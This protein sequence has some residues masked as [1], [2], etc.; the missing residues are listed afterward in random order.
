[1]TGWYTSRQISVDPSTNGAYLGRLV[2]FVEWNNPDLLSS[3]VVLINVEDVYILFNRRIGPNVESQ[4][5]YDLV[6][7]TQGTSSRS[8]NLAGLNSTQ[9]F[10]YTGYNGTASTL[11][12]EVCD[13]AFGTSFDYALVSLY[14]Q[15]SQS[16]LCSSTTPAPIALQ[17][18]TPSIAPTPKA[19]TAQPVVT[20]QTA[21]PSFE[22]TT[23]SPDTFNP[24]STFPATLPPSS[25]SGPAST[26]PATLPPSS[27]SGS[28]LLTPPSA[29]LSTYQPSP[30]AATFSPTRA[31]SIAPTRVATNPPTPQVA[32]SP[33]TQQ[34]TNMLPTPLL[35][36][37]P[38]PVATT[39]NPTSIAT[40]NKPTILA[41]TGQPSALATTGQPSALAT[42]H[43]PVGSPSN[44]PLA[45]PS[46][47]PKTP[48]LSTATTHPVT[49]RPTVNSTPIFNSS[50]TRD[51]GPAPASGPQV[52]PPYLFMV[53]PQN[54]T[55]QNMWLAHFV[56][57][58]VLHFFHTH[59]LIW[60]SLVRACVCMYSFFF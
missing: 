15:G 17:T 31:A 52:V 49:R 50:D 56:F 12:I 36:N 11:M 47:A 5:D 28:T 24:A 55:K 39:N 23:L 32:T 25:G 27:G 57:H 1:M 51:G 30:Q 59:F 33:P 43:Q 9:S 48:T 19:T 37:L 54:G 13:I 22:P 34:A 18:L 53:S 41:T 7:V 2:A 21:F 38:A 60:V 29:V 6:T 4:D 45:V 40:T 16:S 44:S 3:D 14:V 46:V 58:S 20:P 10:A 26:F 8:Y 42:T 35:S